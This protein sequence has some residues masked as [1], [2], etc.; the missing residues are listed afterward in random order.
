MSCGELLPHPHGYILP[1]WQLTGQADP[2]ACLTCP[3]GFY[4]DSAGMT[5]PTSCP[6]GTYRD[7]TGGTALANCTACPAGTY[8]GLL[9]A[10]SL[11]QCLSLGG[12]RTL[13]V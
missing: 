6:T 2:A 7:A 1:C 9:N 3:A 8:Q 13:R 5:S 10:S 12:S 11:S 4:C